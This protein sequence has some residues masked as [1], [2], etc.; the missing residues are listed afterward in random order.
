MKEAYSKLLNLIQEDFPLVPEPFKVLAEKVGL[1]E[2]EVLNFLK[3][4]SKKGILRHLGAS[5]DSHKLGHFTCLCASALPEEALHI[6]EEI[7]NLPQVTHAYL[8]EHKLNFWFTL[9]LP[10]EQDLEPM[11]SQ[12]ERTYGIKI[13]AFPALRKYK[14]K[15]VFSF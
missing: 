5:P 15:A 4:L 14:V 12:L 8:R 11:L 13:L 10:S 9:V 7:A 1:K 2:E 3:E 6:A